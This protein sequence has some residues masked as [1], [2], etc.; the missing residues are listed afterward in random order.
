MQEK[1]IRERVP[2][3]IDVELIR[4]GQW[5]PIQ[6]SRDL[7]MSG[8]QLVSEA[9]LEVGEVVSLRFLVEDAEGNPELEGRVVR[10][11]D[12]NGVWQVGVQFEHLS[13]DTSL[14]LYRIIQYHRI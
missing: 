3:E 7:S 9:P 6:Q 10:V 1:R 8:I 11:H 13:S 14:F 4:T 12:D 5:V 2:F